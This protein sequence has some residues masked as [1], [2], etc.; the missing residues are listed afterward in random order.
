MKKS[1][2]LSLLA[3]FVLIPATLFLGSRLSGRQYYITITLVI[4]EVMIPFFVSFE[5]RKPQPRE[6][7]TIA[8]MAAL[9]AASRA[10]FAF[11]PHFKPITGIIMITGMAFGAEA[12][13]LTGAIAI[14]ASNFLFAQ[15]PW[16]PWQMLAYGI[17]GFLPG[18]LF[19]KRQ[20]KLKP[21]KMGIL[22]FFYVLLVLGPMLDTCTVFTSLTKITW[23]AVAVV[24][25]QGLPLNAV[26]ALATGL[27]LLFFMKPLIGKL[28][29]LQVK[30]GMVGLVD[31]EEEEHL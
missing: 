22:G 31:R 14:F 25:A 24:F 5:S 2:L 6:L 29:R 17:A 8:V 27:T 1:M 9:A 7:V 3:M 11:L 28:H 13:F 15:G 23:P 16:T 18:L 10:V 26:H 4:L 21:M 20:H 30:Y 19:H 12:G